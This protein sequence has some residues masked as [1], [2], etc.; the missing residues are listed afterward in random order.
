MFPNWRWRYLKSSFQSC[1][2]W[3]L[4]KLTVCLI[5]SKVR[6]DEKIIDNACEA[7]SHHCKFATY[8]NPKLVGGCLLPSVISRTHSYFDMK[9]WSARVTL[10]SKR[11]QTGDFGIIFISTTHRR[12]CGSGLC[13]ECHLLYSNQYATI[14]PQTVESLCTPKLVALRLL[15]DGATYHVLIAHKNYNA[16]SH[17]QGAVTR[18]LL[19]CLPELPSL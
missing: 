1:P 2:R 8:T 7:K 15:T 17:L 19:G 14:T 3:Q 9:A 6:L 12:S 11:L 4:S 5:A 10:T 18:M 13:F 16:D